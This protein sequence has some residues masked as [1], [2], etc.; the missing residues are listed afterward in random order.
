MKRSLGFLVLATALGCGSGEKPLAFANVSGTATFD[1]VP[2]E[3]GEITFTI[4]GMPMSTMP[5]VDG[6]FFGS[7]MVG[8]NRIIVSAKK[9]S[10]TVRKVSADEKAQVSGYMEKMKG[11]GGFGSHAAGYDPNMVEYIPASW[12]PDSKQTRVVEAGKPN[13]YQFEIR[14]DGKGK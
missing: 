12:G 9:K 4:P 11:S 14:G 1:G 3:K 5:I 13:E 2:I 7:A 6:K 10:A 8:G